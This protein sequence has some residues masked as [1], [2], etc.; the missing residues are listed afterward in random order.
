ML[1]FFFNTQPGAGSPQAQKGSTKWLLTRTNIHRVVFLSIL[2]F[3]TDTHN[4]FLRS[5]GLTHTRLVHS[6]GL[7]NPENSRLRAPGLSPLPLP[8]LST[9]LLE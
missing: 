6:C 7:S 4:L 9:F 1:F 8:C 3:Y 2:G 5:S